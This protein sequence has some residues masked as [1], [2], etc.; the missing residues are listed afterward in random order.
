[1]KKLSLALTLLMLTI[2]TTSMA[3]APHMST[4]Q[5]EKTHEQQMKDI[6]N[7]HTFG[8]SDNVDKACETLGCSPYNTPQC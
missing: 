1:M 5:V 6:C 7:Q 2:G 4:T 8:T 3:T